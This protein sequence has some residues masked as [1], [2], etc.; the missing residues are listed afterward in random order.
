MGMGPKTG[1]G[2]GY[3]SGF[4]VPGYANPAGMGAGFGGGRG[5]GMGRGRGYRRMYN[6]T[7][8]PAWARYG[9]AAADAPAFDEKAVLRSQAEALEAQL[10]QVNQRLT[11]LDTQTE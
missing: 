4:A 1:R 3:C 7:G 8:L 11:D 5:C 9:A 2:L 10:K 6:A